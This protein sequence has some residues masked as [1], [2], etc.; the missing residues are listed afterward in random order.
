MS[1]SLRWESDGRDWPLREHSR[2]VP[3]GSLRWHAQVMGHGP[4]ILLLHGTGAATHSWRDMAPLLA[5]DYTVIA[6]D[7]PGHGFT[8]GRPRGGLTLDGISSALEDLL[9]ALDIKPA[10]VV[11]HSAGAAIGLQLAKR[12]QGDIPVVGFNPALLPFPGPAANLF[13]ALAKMLFVNPLVPRFFARML[14]VPGETERFLKRATGS[15]IDA[16]GLACYETLLTN[17]RHCAGALG[18]MANWDLQAFADTLP[19]ND[20]PAL[21]VHWSGDSAVPGWSA[22]EA[23]GLLPRGEVCVLPR[24]GHLA[25]E[26]EPGAA[27]EIIRQFAA[28]HGIQ[29]RKEA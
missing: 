24:L 11:G 13:P 3:T 5:S 1:G 18:M 27:C 4:A 21:L 28:D 22:K 19:A 29:S 9:S 23:A 8:Q 12:A 25:H 6:P 7:L 17:S 15:T 26:E 10:M 14:R 2:F 20:C 16:R